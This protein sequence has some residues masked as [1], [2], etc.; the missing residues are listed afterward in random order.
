[1]KALSIK[2]N[3]I[4]K[5]LAIDKSSLSLYLSGERKINKLVKAAFY[6]YF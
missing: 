4:I 2:R 6:F 1:M 5:Q 3:D